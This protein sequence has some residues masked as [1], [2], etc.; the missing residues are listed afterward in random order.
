MKKIY[1]VLLALVF[2]FSAKS[3]W[4]WDYGV[5]IGTTNYIGDIVGKDKTRQNFISDIQFAKTRYNIGGFV[6]YKFRPKLSLK[7]ALDYVRIEGDDKLSTNPGRH[8]RNFNF[9]NN[10]FDFGLTG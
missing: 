8:Y 3:Q 1:I 6:R 5:A 7:L 9:R 2:S 10:L 4:V